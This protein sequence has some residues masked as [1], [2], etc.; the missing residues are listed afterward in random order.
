MRAPSAITC[1]ARTLRTAA[2]E[3]RPERLAERIEYAL[4]EPDPRKALLAMT[5]LQL[6]TAQM[7][8]DVPNVVRARQWLSEGRDLLAED[9][10]APD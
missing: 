6:E 10:S 5:E 9:S 1:A 4:T 7:A 8:P 2:L 3:R